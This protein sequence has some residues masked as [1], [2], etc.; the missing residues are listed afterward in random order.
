MT[1]SDRH[2]S[3]VLRGTQ[4]E[5]EPREERQRE[6][7]APWIR[8]ELDQVNCEREFENLGIDVPAWLAAYEEGGETVRHLWAAMMLALDVD[9]ASSI[10]CGLRVRAGNLDGFILRRALRGD[11]LPDP[12]DYIEVAGEMLDAV[13][14]AGP[15][16][17]ATTK[18]R[19]R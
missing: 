4:A 10:L 9:T 13:N 14:E 7:V 3:D 5:I 19:K 18:G 17:A 12:E 8:N 15:L 2:P 6:A 16:P 1:P 11:P